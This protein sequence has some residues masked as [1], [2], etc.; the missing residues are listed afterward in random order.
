MYHQRKIREQFY[1]SKINFDPSKIGTKDTVDLNN[2]LWSSPKVW[3]TWTTRALNDIVMGNG[4]KENM[5]DKK[6]M[7]SILDWKAFILTTKLCHIWLI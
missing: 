2:N 5:H 6:Y 1:I 7:I 3:K 4:V